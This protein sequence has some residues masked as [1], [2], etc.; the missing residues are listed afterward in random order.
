M[1]VV[2]EEFL[3]FETGKME[4]RYTIYP[5]LA[6]DASERDLAWSGRIYVRMHEG[7]PTMTVSSTMEHMS[8]RQSIELTVALEEANKLMWKFDV[9]PV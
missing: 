2:K 9:Q 5:F 1:K 3:N 7:K 4:P 6:E 8:F